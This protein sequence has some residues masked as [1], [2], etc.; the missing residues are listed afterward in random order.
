VARSEPSAWDASDVARRG[1]EA[2]AA[3]QLRALLA[4]E[5]AGKSVDPARVV[6]ARDAS[7][8][9]ELPFALSGAAGQDAA[10]E[11]CKPDAGQSG[12]QSCAA[13]VFAAQQ[14]LAE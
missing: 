2:D 6:P 5:D 13:Q 10:A 14:Q 7:F 9:P 1:E 3:H 12:E 4:D 8:P 11:L